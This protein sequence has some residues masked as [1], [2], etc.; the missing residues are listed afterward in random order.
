[1]RVQSQS[2]QEQV[3]SERMPIELIEIW[4]LCLLTASQ[5]LLAPAIPNL[6]ATTTAF[7]SHSPILT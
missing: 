3:W 6:R 7:L 4:Q 5:A 2:S 1:M